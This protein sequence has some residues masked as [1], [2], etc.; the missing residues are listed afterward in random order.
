MLWQVAVKKTI[1][2]EKLDALIKPYQGQPSALSE[3]LHKVQDSI[4]YLP[5]EVQ[6]RLPKPLAYP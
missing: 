1:D 2:M 5:R 4:G 3:V 6:V